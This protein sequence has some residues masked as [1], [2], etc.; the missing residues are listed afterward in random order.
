MMKLTKPVLL[1]PSKGEDPKLKEGGA[2]AE[3]V[4][5]QG[6]KSITFADMEHG[7]MCRGDLTAPEVARDVEASMKH[8]VEFFKANLKDAPRPTPPAC[9]PPNSWPACAAPEG[10]KP[11][12]TQLRIDDLAAYL[13]G[14]GEK[15][16]LLLPD[17][18]PWSTM[19]GR[20]MGIADTLAEEGYKVLLIDPFRGESAEGLEG[21][22]MYGWIGKYKYEESV[23]KDINNAYKFLQDKGCTAIGC[24]GF[25][26]G[27][28]AMCKAMS[29][30]VGFVCG[31]GPHPSTMIETALMG[32]DE[33]A[34]MM[35]LTKPVL[36]MPSKGEDPKLKE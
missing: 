19:K 34:M 26:W 32:R 8:T 3:H 5:K 11:K 23:G 29:E 28:W 16:I 36:L 7:F 6:G 25:C 2:I 10:Y 30:G 9:C 12:G 1:M 20:L 27:V 22:D 14:E 17:I 24:M 35:K 4:V 21:N 33:D 15:G 31:V 13:V 18:Y